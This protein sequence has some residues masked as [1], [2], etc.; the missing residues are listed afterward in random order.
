VV[1]ERDLE[2]KK[3]AVR[4][5]GCVHLALREI[6]RAHEA[7]AQRGEVEAGHADAITSFVSPSFM[8]TVLS[9]RLQLAVRPQP[10]GQHPTG[11]SQR[12]SLMSASNGRELA[13]GHGWSP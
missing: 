3:L 8:S 12:A 4:N 10:H 1:V 9:I 13:A 11:H 5:E 7:R 6:Q 2:L